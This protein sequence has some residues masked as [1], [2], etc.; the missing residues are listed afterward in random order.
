MKAQEILHLVADA[1]QKAELAPCLGE[2]RW[3]IAER[4]LRDAAAALPAAAQACPECGGDHPRQ[5]LAESGLVDYHRCNFTGIHAGVLTADLAA[6]ADGEEATITS[7]ALAG[8]LLDCGATN[9]GASCYRLSTETLRL[10]AAKLSDSLRAR[11]APSPVKVNMLEHANGIEV[12][13]VLSDGTD[14]M[15]VVVPHD[16]FIP[17]PSHALVE[18]ADAMR[19]AH[20][21]CGDLDGPDCCKAARAYDLARSS[22]PAAKMEGGS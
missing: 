13:E 21:K 20:A 17:A 19:R 11:P 15:V 4:A 2:S 1:M 12:R 16:V 9:L 5:L 10:A 3:A 6:Q 22:L 18:A 7:E 14:R 8:A